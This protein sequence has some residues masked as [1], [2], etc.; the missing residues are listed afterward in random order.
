MAISADS[1]EVSG[2]TVVFQSGLELGPYGQ[3]FILDCDLGKG[4]LPPTEAVPQGAN[5]V[6]SHNSSP[7]W[8]KKKISFNGRGFGQ[9]FAI[10][11]SHNRGPTDHFLF[12]PAQEHSRE[13]PSSG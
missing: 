9:C 8:S 3:A 11:S 2:A 12:V 4:W 6:F 13:N 5:L 10:K 1:V 7:A